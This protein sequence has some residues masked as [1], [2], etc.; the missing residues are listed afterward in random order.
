HPD[1]AV[2]AFYHMWRYT[3]NVRGLYETPLPSSEGAVDRAAA[4]KAIGVA[5]DTGRTLL[6][7]AEAKQLLSAYGIPTVPTLTCTSE[8]G[9]VRAAEQ[10]SYPVVLKLLSA[11]ITHKSDVGGVQLNLQGPDAVRRSYR[12]IE[13]RVQELAG[14][15]HF[16]G[17][18][19]QPMI[20]SEG[21]EIIL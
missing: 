9:A 13:S 4:G 14:P 7:E 8:D 21:Y 19:V 15:R 12:K 16:D 18:T 1:T 11:T 3:Y 2:R 10:L 17:V 20:L 6:N 5:R